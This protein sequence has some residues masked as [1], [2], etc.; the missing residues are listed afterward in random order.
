MTNAKQKEPTDAS[1]RYITLPNFHQIPMLLLRQCLHCKMTFLHTVVPLLALITRSLA[2]GVHGLPFSGPNKP[3]PGE[4]AA[5]DSVFE[6]AGRNPNATAAVAFHRS[7]HAVEETWTW[8]IN[9]T[10]EA[11]PDRLQD[12]GVPSANSSQGFHVLNTQW[13]LEWPS[14]NNSESLQSFLGARNLSLYINVLRT[15]VPSNLTEKYTNDT[16]GTARGSLGTSA[17]SL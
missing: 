3:G 7:Y 16:A 2:Q 9:V 11:I 17:H 14:Q 8:R 13:Q 15:A 6:T 5:A 4:T 10:D 1:F 12:I